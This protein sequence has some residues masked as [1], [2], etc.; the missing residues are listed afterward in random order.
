SAENTA[1]HPFLVMMLV[2]TGTADD[3]ERIHRDADSVIS[4]LVDQLSA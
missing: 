2:S 1:S 4:A 3:A